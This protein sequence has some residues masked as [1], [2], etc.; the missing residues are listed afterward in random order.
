MSEEV[1]VRSEGG[2]LWIRW[3]RPAKKN[4]L[5]IPMYRAAT[6]ALVAAAGDRTRVVVLAGHPGAFTA[7]NDLADFMA[8]QSEL[9][10]VLDFLAAAEALDKPLLAAVDGVAIGIGTTILLHCDAAWATARSLFKTPFVD[11]GLV[12]EAGSSLLLGQLIGQRAASEM[13]LAGR[14][15]DGTEAARLGL[16]NGLVEPD[17]L[18]AHV[19]Q[20]AADLADKAPAALRA[21]KALIRGAQ[22]ERVRAAMQAEAE[23]FATR[24]AAPEFFEAASAFMQ[25]RKPDFSRFD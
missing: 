16:V 24:L 8:R 15:L 10:A 17:V 22:R 5:T 2:V 4:A 20:R 7:G 3:D 19:A 12:P 18:E 25:K 14:A 13:L 1:S 11:L 23:V 21:S 9:S 6:A